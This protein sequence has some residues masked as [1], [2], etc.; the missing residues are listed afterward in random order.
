MKKL[1]SRGALMAAVICGSMGMVWEAYAAEGPQEEKLAKYDLEQIVVTATRTEKTVLDVPANT[2]IITSKELK[3]GDYITVF[4]AVRNLTQASAS[5]YDE[6]GGDWS[7]SGMSSRIKLRGIDSGTLILVNGAPSNYMNFGT[8]NS[9]PMDQIERI[10]IVKGSGSVLYGPQAMGGVINIITK[11]PGQIEKMGGNIF[12]TIGNRFKETGLNVETNIVNVGARKSFTKDRFNVQRL[13]NT[14]S[15]TSI[16]I[17]D[18]KKNQLYLNAQLAKNLTFNYGRAENESS[19]E[20]KNSTHYVVDRHYESHG[21][22]TFNNYGLFYNNP[23]NKLMVS[24]GY[25]KMDYNTVYNRHLP[26]KYFDN[27][28]YGDNTEL[29]IQKTF[30]LRD[31]KDSLTLGANYNKE[32]M[33]FVYNGNP[34]GNSRKSYALYQSYDRKI[35]DKFNLILGLREYWVAKSN[36]QNSDFQVLPQIQGNY[37]INKNSSYYFNSGKAFENPQ[38][39]AG[40]NYF[41]MTLFEPNPD[42]KPQSSWSHEIG[43][44]YDDEDRTFTVDVFYMNVKDKFASGKAPSGASITINKDKWRNMGL[45]L[46]YKQKINQ[47]LTSNIGFTLQN[48][49]GQIKGKE[50]KQDEAKYVLNIGSQYNRG[51]FSADARIFSYFGRQN[52]YYKYDGSVAGNH[53]DH[54]IGSSCDFTLSLAYRPTEMDT[55]KITGRNLF[56]RDDAFNNYEYRATPINYIVTYERKF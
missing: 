19:Y 28:F 21:K 16:N 17:K 37:R 41:G 11:K 38:I 42:L 56:D 52:A 36:Y 46:N 7:T 1:I 50:W 24:F 2:T 29:N 15:G 25:N 51:K 26:F 9:I 48:P 54:K 49:E 6:D 4:E 31:R 44:K 33:N 39:S 35:T 20:V 8:L 23:E 55:I 30:D 45:E 5:Q 34:G 40:F 13:G 53:A 14:G 32:K 10:E 3:D 12:G 18:K 43:Y 27:N 47:Y 22:S